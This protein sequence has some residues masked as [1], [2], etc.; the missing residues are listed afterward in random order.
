[1]NCKLYF[2]VVTCLRAAPTAVFEDS[3][4]SCHSVSQQIIIGVVQYFD[5]M[6]YFEATFIKH[7]FLTPSTKEF[8]YY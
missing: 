8:A 6:Q 1:M 3:A 4:P 7:Y 5:N 2:N